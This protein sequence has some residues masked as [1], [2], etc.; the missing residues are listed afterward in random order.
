MKK[1]LAGFALALGLSLAFAQA[2][3]PQTPA[4]SPST[5]AASVVCK[6]NKQSTAS[7][8]G[9]GARAVATCGAS[10]S[11]PVAKKVTPAKSVSTKEVSTSERDNAVLVKALAEAN[12]ALRLSQSQG[13]IPSAVAFHPAPAVAEEGK[14]YT[15]GVNT[16]ERHTAGTRECKVL[17]NGQLVKR[18]FVDGDIVSSKKACDA[19]AAEVLA[20][21]RLTSPDGRDS[22]VTVNLP[23]TSQQPATP[24]SVPQVKGENPGHLCSMTFNGKPVFESMKME[25]EAACNAHREK[26]ANERGWTRSPQ[27]PPAQKPTT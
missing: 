23:S 7:A 26:I 17:A 18:A 2:T 25:S 12:I 5:A 3:A 20:S 22:P 19:F 4:S 10:A 27:Q 6:D 8:T 21:M 14:V 13:Q 16:F 15:D 24:N 9:N 11:K 1:I